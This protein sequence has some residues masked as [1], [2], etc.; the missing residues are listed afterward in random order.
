VRIIDAD[1]TVT[2][3]DGTRYTATYRLATTLLDARRQPARRLIALYHER[4][5]HEIAYWRCDTPSPT[6]AS[7]DRPTPS[8]SNRKCGRCWP[9][10]RHCGVPW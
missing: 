2:C 7:C 3:A 8:A 10:T 9:S 1:I 5:E 4:W 6:A